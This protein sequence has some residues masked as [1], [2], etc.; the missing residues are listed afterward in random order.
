[1]VFFCELLNIILVI[2]VRLDAFALLCEN[3]KTTEVVSDL[4][5]HLIRD[6]IPYNLNNQMPS[7]RQH[8]LSHL[9]KVIYT[10]LLIQACLFSRLNNKKYLQNNQHICMEKI[11]NF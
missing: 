5:L 10:I 7:F 6:F 4:E 9:K 8:F 1:M 11:C 2:Q 3:Q